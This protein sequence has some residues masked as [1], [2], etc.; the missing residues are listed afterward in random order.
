MNKELTGLN[1]REWARE[2]KVNG[3][4]YVF[5]SGK[6]RFSASLMHNELVRYAIAVARLAPLEQRLCQ[7][8]FDNLEKW[9]SAVFER[10][11]YRCL[12]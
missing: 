6:H 2:T 8:Y 3:F 11:P 12:R 4:L 10:A 7:P 1:P 5:V 9:H